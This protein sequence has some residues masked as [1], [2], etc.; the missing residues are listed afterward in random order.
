MVCARMDEC[1]LFCAFKLA[2]AM[3]PCLG[4]RYYISDFFAAIKLSVLAEK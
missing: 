3:L 2:Q 4:W 1:L